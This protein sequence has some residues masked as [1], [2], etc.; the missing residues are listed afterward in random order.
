VETEKRDRCAEVLFNARVQGKTIP[1]LSQTFGSLTIQE[2]YEIQNRGL[3]MR[4]LQGEKEIGF[5]M[6]LTS[7]AKMEQMG[8]H[9]PIYGVLLDHTRHVQESAFSLSGKIHPKIEPEIGL[10]TTRE[11]KGQPTIEEAYAA[12]GF[13]LMA[14]EILDSRYHGFK[15][16]TLPDVVADNSSSGYFILGAPREVSDFSLERLSQIKV[17]LVENEAI[18][19]TGMSSAVLGNPVQSLCAL[20]SLLSLTNQGLPANSLVLT[21][22]ITAALPLRAGHKIE[23]RFSLFGNPLEG[24]GVHVTD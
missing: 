10:V 2:A 11:L 19:E 1:P 17:D 20:V 7:K 24:I 22:A 23:G 3:Q 14:L 5:K 4:L 9:T 21:G 6:G 8:L 18:R 12:C 16:F 13:V 15:Y